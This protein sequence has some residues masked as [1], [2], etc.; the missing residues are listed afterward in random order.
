MKDSQYW[1]L[2][3]IIFGLTLEATPH[4]GLWDRI[5]FWGA[6]LL[7]V[8]S[9]IFEYIEDRRKQKLPKQWS[10]TVNFESQEHRNQFLDGITEIIEEAN[11]AI[12]S[13]K[14]APVKKPGRPR[15]PATK[16]SEKS[17]D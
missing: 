7:F 12:K 5:P 6:L 15:K 2:V 13:T 10:V 8:L 3:V 1:F 9:V 11:V 17:E 16:T 4:P 14:I